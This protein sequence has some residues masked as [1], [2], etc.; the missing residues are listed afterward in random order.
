MTMSRTESVLKKNPQKLLKEDL[1][2][3]YDIDISDYFLH[4][5]TDTVQGGNTLISHGMK[6]SEGSCERS[7]HWTTP[8]SN[9][10]DNDCNLHV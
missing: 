2:R 7:H 10:T 1:K 4:I 3:G 9:N 8:D 5:Y 6:G